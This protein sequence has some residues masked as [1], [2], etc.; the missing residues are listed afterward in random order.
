MGSEM[1]PIVKNVL[2]YSTKSIQLVAKSDTTD[3]D[4]M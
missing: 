2:V 1:G 3:R 4:D